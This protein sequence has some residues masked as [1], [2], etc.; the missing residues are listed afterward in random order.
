MTPHPMN[1]R[2]SHEYADISFDGRI[3]S[4]S[5]SRCAAKNEG[6]SYGIAYVVLT[7]GNKL[8]LQQRS[9]AKA[10]QPGCW[11]LSAGGHVEARDAESSREIDAAFRRA[12]VRE[13]REELGIQVYPED[14]TPLTHFQ[15]DMTTQAGAPYR[16]FI[17]VYT[18]ELPRQE[19]HPDLKREETI[20]LEWVTGAKLARLS[21]LVVTKELEKCREVLLARFQTE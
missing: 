6:H 21:P 4:G 2:W 12:A 20:R 16:K 14:L 7:I 9:P 8:L 15:E 3:I 17:R 1:E 13:L 19:C 10:S 11:D 18:C 5:V